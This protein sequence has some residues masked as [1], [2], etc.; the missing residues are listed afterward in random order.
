VKNA[1][2]TPPAAKTKKLATA[3]SRYYVTVGV[4]KSRP[5][6]AQYLVAVVAKE[7]GGR[8]VDY[9]VYYER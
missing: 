7:I 5:T 8:I 4:P 9:C 3:P 2:S 1:P 6:E